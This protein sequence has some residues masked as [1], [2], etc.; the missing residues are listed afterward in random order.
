MLKQQHQLFVALLAAA[1][2]AIIAL[3]C[4]V[5]WLCR[6]GLAEGHL[7]TSWEDWV[8]LPLLVFAVPIALST[9]W[10]V[11]LYRPRRDRS[12]FA[13]QGA[14]F[15]AAL[16]ALAAL[17]IALWA[18]EHSVATGKHASGVPV[19]R[20][21][22]WG[23]VID[24]GRLQLALL[25]FVLPVMLGAHRAIFRILV[26]AVRRR[27]RNLRHV[28]IIGVGRLGQIVE[29]TLS[30]NSWTGL[31][32]AYFISH[33]P[34]TKKRSCHSHPVLGGID[35]LESILE[36]NR[37]DAVYL[38]VP[39]AQAA[40]LPPL[41]ARLDR[42]AVDVRIVPDVHPRF[43]PQSMVVNELDGM[44]ILSYRECPSSGLGGFSKRTLDILG[45]LAALTLFSPILLA[46]MAA[47]RLSSP[48]PVIFKQRRV[49]IGSRVFKIYKLRTMRHL[50]DEQWVQLK[51]SWT[52]RDDPRVT[53]VG[54]FLRRTSLDELPQLINVLKGQM[55]LV[56][57][58]PERPEL[59]ER[60]REDWR[61]YMI[62]QH[63]KAGI[64]GWAQV[65]GLRG[66]TSLRKRLQYDLFY[67]RHWSIG[68]DVRI[69]WLTL[70]RGFVNRNAH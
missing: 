20:A 2:G 66:Q 26:R 65:N 4:L 50:E 18:V 51:D 28:A 40:L 31:S 53:P 60:F 1:D 32:V 19:A 56:G 11:G 23:M 14:I 62:R 47:V 10:A 63:V 41:L 68:F 34:Q 12:L 55:S 52:L 7:P 5:A 58:R 21:N 16:A 37:V 6:R 43:V 70:F 48:G 42:F 64:T 45:S 24:G 59:I 49:S 17:V 25:A 57:P 27:G 54:R 35:N 13:E 46:A 9:M 38:A 36:A 30:R 29:R 33:H 22:L 8:K 61:G 67:I 39:N 69:L 3:A 44:P 15:R